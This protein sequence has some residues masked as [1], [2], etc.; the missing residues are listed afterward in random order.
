MSVGLYMDEHV[1]RAIT[2][3]LRLRGVD[4]LTAQEDNRRR[5]SDS[6]LLDRATELGRILFTQDSDLL[7]EATRRQRM[8]EFFAGIIY[9][10]PLKV[11]VGECIEDLILLTTVGE[12]DDF[13]NQVIFL[14]LK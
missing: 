9:A 11:T 3:G 12:P 6:E 1:P 8:G 10:H 14:P 7:R 2:E 13:A 4:V 5:A